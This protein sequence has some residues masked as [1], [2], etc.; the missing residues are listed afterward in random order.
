M[1]IGN[2]YTTDQQDANT[3][4]VINL[5]YLRDDLSPNFGE[6]VADALSGYRDQRILDAGCGSATGVP[7]L[8]G[9]DNEVVQVDR[10]RGSLYRLQETYD[11]LGTDWQEYRAPEMYHADLRALPFTDDSM[12]I[13]FIG[14]VID[15]AT[16]D[17]GRLDYSTTDVLRVLDTG[18]DLIVA[19]HGFDQLCSTAGQALRLIMHDSHEEIRDRF[20]AASLDGAVLTLHRYTP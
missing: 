19:D 5:S 16:T 15:S 17:G 8:A 13:V 2:D 6:P 18:G 14:G 20:D 11:A 12:D 10:H 7:A 4:P 1:A 9:E 3:E